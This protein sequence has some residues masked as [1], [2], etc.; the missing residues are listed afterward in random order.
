MYDLSGAKVTVLGL[1][2]HGGGI[3]TVRFLSRNGARVTVTDMK[4]RE[5]LSEAIEKI[6]GCFEHARF[7]G[8]DE[9]DIRNADLVIKNPAVPRTA[10]ILD[11]A[12]RIE[13]DISLFLERYRGPLIAVTG[14]KGKSTVS[15]LIHAGLQAKHPDARLGGNITVSPLSYLEKLS[16]NTA[17]VLELSSFQ[18][19]D[20]RLCDSVRRK[21]VSLKPAVSVITCIY[22]DHQNYYHDNMEAY[23]QDKEE[24]F[25]SQGPKDALILGCDEPW[26]T[27]FSRKA[28]ARVVCTTPTDGSMER[29]RELARRA[30]SLFGVEGADT[31]RRLTAFS[32]L[33]HRLECV[34]RIGSL[35]IYNDSAATVPEATAAA[36]SAL[37]AARTILITGGTDKHLHLDGFAESIRDAAHIVLLAGSATRRMQY[38]LDLAGIE[39]SGPCATLSECLSVALEAARSMGACAADRPDALSASIA[40]SPGAASFE[41]FDNEFARGRAFKELVSALPE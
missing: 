25:L 21:Q 12:H 1:G 11:K 18:L 7:G 35:S 38:E 37:G 15:S 16:R 10:S 27:R 30:L 20:L 19:G 32:G 31:D 40:F 41:L 36:L 24:I 8:H 28:S 9:S 29:N 17:V 5:T 34:R 22:P 23:V 4:P 3:E 13:T 6:D 2:L 14:S 33:E 26:R 39:Y